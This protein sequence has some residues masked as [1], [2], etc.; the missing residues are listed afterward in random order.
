MRLDVLVLAGLLLSGCVD[1][2][3][4]VDAAPSASPVATSDRTLDR[5]SALR[6]GGHLDYGE[7]ATGSWDSPIEVVRRWLGNEAEGRQ[8]K[9]VGAGTVAVKDGERT[10]SLVSLMAAPGDG[11]LVSSYTGCSGEVAFP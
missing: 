8:L 9:D 7:D 5:G 6:E 2:T 1:D 11:L 4:G 3:G 10:L